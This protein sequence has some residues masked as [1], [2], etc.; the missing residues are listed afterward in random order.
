MIT[1]IALCEL[2]NNLKD[3]IEASKPSIPV[4]MLKDVKADYQQILRQLGASKESIDVAHVTRLKNQLLSAIPGLVAQ[5][6]GKYVILTKESHGE[7]IYEASIVSSRNEGIVISKAAKV[8]RK[9]M[10][11]KTVTFNGNLGYDQQ[12]ESVPIQL[13]H[14]L[15]LILEGVKN[16]DTVT[17]STEGIALNLSQL[18]HFNAVKTKRSSANVRRSKVN[19]PPFPV[20][21]GLSL[22]AQTR[23]KSVIEFLSKRGLCIAYERILDIEDN[24]TAQVC[25]YYEDENIV[26][27]PSMVP[28]EFTVG[29]IDNIDHNPSSSTA[30]QSFHGTSISIFQYPEVPKMKQKKFEYKPDLVKDHSPKLPTSYTEI[31]P[32]KESNAEIPNTEYCGVSPIKMS[33]QSLKSKDEMKAWTDKLLKSNK[34]DANGKISFTGF[35]AR[36]QPP[37]IKKTRSSLLPLLSDSVNSAAMVRHCIEVSL[38]ITQKLNPGQITVLTADQPVYAIG[39]QVQWHYNKKY[40]LFWMMGPLH[41]EMVMLS[42]I[43]D[44]LE[45]SG[46]IQVFEKAG[47][48]TTGRIESFLT[49]KKV[50]RTRYAHLL[51]LSALSQLM[52]AAFE[53]S[54]KPDFEI[55]RKDLVEDNINANFWSQVIQMETL[56][57]QFVKSLRSADFQLF[58][59]SIKEIVPWMFALDHTHYARW[60]SVF[61]QDL[62]EVSPAL[63]K[64]FMDGKF[65]VQKSEHEFS[66]IAIDQAHEQNN[67][68]VKIKGGAIGILENENALIRWAVAGPILMDL[69]DNEKKLGDTK[70]HEDNDSY[71]KR[72]RNELESLVKAFNEYG[73][74]FTEK[75]KNNLVQIATK[76]VMNDDAT[77]AVSNALDTGTKQFEKFIEERLFKKDV[78]IHAIITRNKYKIFQD[79]NLSVSR[80]KVEIQTLKADR[81]LFSRLYIACQSRQG[82]LDN[83]FSH[84]NHSYPPSISEYGKLRK[85]TSKSDFLKCLLMYGEFQEEI[86]KVDAVVIDGAAFVN[87]NPPKD[88]P[89]FQG[90]CK[91]MLKKVLIVSQE[92]KRVDVCFDV[93]KKNS[94][95]LQTRENRG[96]GIRTLVLENTP[97]PKDFISFIRIDDNKTELF[98]MFAETL[99]GLESSIHIVATVNDQVLSNKSSC[100]KAFIS[101]C[102]HEEADTRVLLHVF[103]V[104]SKGIKKVK[105][106][107][108]DTDVVVIALYHY[109]SLD[110]DEFWIEFGVGKN[111]R[112]L[113][114]HLYAEAMGEELCRGLPFWYCL[115]GCDTVSMFSGRGKKTAWKVWGV[116][117]EATKAFAW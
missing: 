66:C 5:K 87:M 96:A 104:V 84:E 61:Y 65:V 31:L 53:D 2:I 74:P 80:A 3:E 91:Q 20:Q 18:V 15:G 41:I 93:Y 17:D 69:C 44:W 111:R 55:W 14:L 8:I 72:F 25:K 35:F 52:Y 50:K 98:K 33:N 19:E 78:S 60:L 39:K 67:K 56:L 68:L 10:F 85:C 16:Y 26:C 9:Y 22:H 90:Y 12:K 58:C 51:S 27:P 1:G 36:E 114:I 102:N 79:R 81:K 24:I 73:N 113:P 38:K 94:L 30:H 34:A 40:E 28:G 46:W 23:E 75:T 103:D 49:G 112:F 29:A 13:L 11:A 100:D 70:H 77:N 71:E 62:M 83:F 6:R 97:V 105:I 108:V 63:F 54:K 116:F 109:F 107:T 92:A 82:D 4:F 110:I 88:S 106:Y 37:K 59:L 64:A 99:A 95:K 21:V 48:S 76:M 47:V 117:P 42:A 115:T 86:P 45:G 32:T 43:G 89:T 57:F 7:A 101:K